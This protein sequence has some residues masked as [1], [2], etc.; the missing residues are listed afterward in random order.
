MKLFDILVENKRIEL[1]ELGSFDPE[2][3]KHAVQHWGDLTYKGHAVHLALE[4]GLAMIDKSIRENP[5]AYTSHDGEI[6]DSTIDATYIEAFYNSTGVYGRIRY[7]FEEIFSR[8]DT[9]DPDN[10]IDNETQREVVDVYMDDK[11]DITVSNRRTPGR[12][13][14]DID[15]LELFPHL[16]GDDDLVGHS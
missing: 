10:D 1:T 4:D 3:L 15:L 16:K 13:Q 8:G 7:E 5:E 2:L 9:D 12:D 14:H 11:G 6:D